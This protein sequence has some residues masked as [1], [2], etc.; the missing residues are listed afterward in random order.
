MEKGRRRVNFCVVFVVVM[1]ILFGYLYYAG[2]DQEERTINEGTLIS[3]LGTE[4]R[5]ICR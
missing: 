2:K 4:L 5:Q 3:S 1:A